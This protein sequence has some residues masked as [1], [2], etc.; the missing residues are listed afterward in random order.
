MCEDWNS[1][2]NEPTF[3][4]FCDVVEAPVPSNGTLG[5]GHAS[6]DE[7]QKLVE[8]PLFDPT[9]FD[10]ISRLVERYSDVRTVSTTF[11]CSYHVLRLSVFS[12]LP[13]T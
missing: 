2:V 5:Y 7:V 8:V 11:P 10:L 13:T 3:S 9:I 1:A 4:E 6:K 12:A